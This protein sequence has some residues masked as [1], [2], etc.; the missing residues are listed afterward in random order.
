MRHILDEK[1]FSHDI[2][3][4]FSY[5]KFDFWKIGTLNILQILQDFSSKIVKWEILEYFTYINDS[6]K[7]SEKFSKNYKIMQKF[8]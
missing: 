1:K 5:F 3:K 7:K 8:L 6:R 4:N 2:F